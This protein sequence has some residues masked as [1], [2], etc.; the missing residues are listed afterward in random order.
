MDIFLVCA[1][2]NGHRELRS[3]IPFRRFRWFSWG[4]I[5]RCGKRHGRH[6]NR[7]RTPGRWRGGVAGRIQFRRGAYQYRRY[8][9]FGSLSLPG[10]LSMAS[11][12]TGPGRR[13]A[14]VYEGVLNRLRSFTMAG[15]FNM[16]KG[17]LMP[18]FRRRPN[19]SLNV[20]CAGWARTAPNCRNDPPYPFNRY[21]YWF[22]K[23]RPSAPIN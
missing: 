14:P 1:R 13:P 10:P 3:A 20:A 7:Y 15:L 5:F 21:E 11:R 18:K 12:S 16:E 17:P 19:Y 4:G 2:L 22:R 8:A 9:C 6:I 23:I